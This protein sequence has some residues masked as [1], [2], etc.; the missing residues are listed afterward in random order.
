MAVPTEAKSYTADELQKKALIGLMDKGVSMDA[1]AGVLN[2]L[3]SQSL[4]PISSDIARVKTV[5]NGHLM[6]GHKG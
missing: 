2:K 1:I 4:R 3:E 5:R 6:A